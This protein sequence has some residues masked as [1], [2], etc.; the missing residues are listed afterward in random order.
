MTAFNIMDFSPNQKPITTNE[1]APTNDKA[2]KTVSAALPSISANGGIIQYP[3]AVNP[4]TGRAYNGAQ[5]AFLVSLSNQF[6]GFQQWLSIGR[7][8]RKG[9]HGV[10]I[11]MPIPTPEGEKQRF[12]GRVIFSIEQTD[13]ATVKGE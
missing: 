1:T 10:K 7:V 6:A 11:L 8:V 9:E 13:I 3:K 12:I 4:V 5:S 2:I